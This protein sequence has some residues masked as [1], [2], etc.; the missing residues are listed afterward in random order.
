MK[1]NKRLISKNKTNVKTRIVPKI[2]ERERRIGNLLI[3]VNL[4]N[5]L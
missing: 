4:I 3:S 1:N 2:R 5:M